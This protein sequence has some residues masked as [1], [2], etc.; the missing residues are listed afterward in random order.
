MAADIDME[1]DSFLKDCEQR[2]SCH[3]VHPRCT[4]A[5]PAATRVTRYLFPMSLH[6]LGVHPRNSVIELL[7]VANISPKTFWNEVEE[8]FEHTDYKVTILTNKFH[9]SS[10]RRRPRKQSS[11]LLVETRGQVFLLEYHQTITPFEELVDIHGYVS[12]TTPSDP[13]IR[14]GTIQY[15]AMRDR[16]VFEGDSFR[17]AASTCMQLAYDGGILSE[18]LELK[19]PQAMANV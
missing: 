8:A 6:G 13:L 17:R 2:L 18:R 7:L 15:L 4:D 3:Y 11:F 10:A 12:Q 16:H 19:T 14:V 1:I 5:L 9:P